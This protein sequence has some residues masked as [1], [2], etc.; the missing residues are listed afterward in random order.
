MLHVWGTDRFGHELWHV[1]DARHPMHDP[2]ESA[3]HAPRCIAY[4]R[5][6]D[7]VLGEWIASAPDAAI[8]VLSDHGFGPIHRFLVFNVWLLERGFLRLGRGLGTFVRRSLF[9]LGV[10]PSLGYRLSMHLGFARFR[11]ASGVGTR[12]RVLKRVNQAFLSLGDVDWSTTRAYSKGNY[13]QIFLNLRG[14]EPHGIVSRGAEANAVLDELTAALREIRDPETGG[15]LIGEV[16]R[17][18]ELYSGPYLDRAPD[19]TF[20]PVDMRN[21]ALGTVDFTSNRFIEWAYGNS[22]D[23]RMNGIFLFR[24]EGVR[25]GASLHDAR[26]LDVAPTILH[27]LGE[28]VPSDFDGHVLVDAL[29]SEEA[30]RPVRITE[31]VR[32][33]AASRGGELTPEEMEEIRSRL[34]GIGYLG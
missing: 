28:G 4:W 32:G 11:L 18:E 1:L 26:L 12:G 17:A 22:G 3:I 9:E 19:L 16:Y 8:L 14:R 2:A 31:G 24:G 33:P 21:K 27:Y 15:A 13:G 23:H 34:K 30:A 25:R 6:V 29:T 7:Q 5:R 20:L 10:T